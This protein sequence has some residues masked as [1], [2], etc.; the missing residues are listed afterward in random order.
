M[1]WREVPRADQDL[2]LPDRASPRFLEAYDL[3]RDDLAALL[4]DVEPPA[5][6]ERIVPGQQPFELR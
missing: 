5:Q 6:A 4:R 1:S 3:V 2:D